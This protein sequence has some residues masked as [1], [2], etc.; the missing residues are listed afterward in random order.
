MDAS[1]TYKFH[2]SCFEDVFVSSVIIKH[3]HIQREREGGGAVREEI[4]ILE[5]ESNP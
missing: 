2:T 5:L 3:T 1:C 4:K